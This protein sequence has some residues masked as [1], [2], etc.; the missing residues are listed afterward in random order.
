[1]TFAHHKV[2]CS[3]CVPAKFLFCVHKAVCLL[4]TNEHVIYADLYH[5]CWIFC[6]LKNMCMPVVTV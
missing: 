1:M 3:S 6:M 5:F 2:T 4:C